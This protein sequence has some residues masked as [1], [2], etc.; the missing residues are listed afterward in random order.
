MSPENH[1]DTLKDIYAGVVAWL[2]FGEAKNA[3]LAT[4]NSAA[5]IGVATIYFD[6]EAVPKW[7]Q[8]WLLAAGGFFLLS[9]LI[10][11][12]S[13]MP[14]LTLFSHSGQGTAKKTN[15]VWFFGH[16]AHMS[17]D[18]FIQNIWEKSGFKTEPNGLARDLAQQIVVN[19][20]I[21]AR[22]YDMFRISLWITLSGLVTPL[23]ALLF[24]WFFIDEAV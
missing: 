17:V 7:I 3:A 14:R 21:A 11:I 18:G 1:L 20:K 16:I 12:V 19:S 8:L 2:H 13:F 9:F 24:Y 23:L 22:K 10:C 6:Q 5:L 15:N 4:L